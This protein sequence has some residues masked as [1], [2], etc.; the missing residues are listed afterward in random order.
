MSD[1]YY[2][3]SCISTLCFSERNLQHHSRLVLEC[4]RWYW[5]L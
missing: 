2:L 4:G 5:I 3:K 1:L